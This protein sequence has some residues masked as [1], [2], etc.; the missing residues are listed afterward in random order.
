MNSSEQNHCKPSKIP[1]LIITPILDIQLH[2][3]SDNSVTLEDSVK[4]LGIIIDQRLNFDLH[5]STLAR[6]ISNSF[7]VITKLK[8][9]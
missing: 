4:Y 7:G 6:K 3:N 9:I 1:C 5:I 2:F 8:Q